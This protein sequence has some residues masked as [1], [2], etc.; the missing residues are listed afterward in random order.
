VS[1]TLVFDG[2]REIW[3][4]WNVQ[5]DLE[6]QGGL[7]GVTM[8]PLAIVF[9]GSG[10]IWNGNRFFFTWAKD[11]WLFLTADTYSQELVDAFSAVVGYRPLCRYRHRCLSDTET[12]AWYV[13][14]EE[15]LKELR[16]EPGVYGLERMDSAQ[17]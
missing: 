4:W 5:L 13:D 11:R 9:G 14:A 1:E 12:V 15:G 10:G 16:A 6:E 8:D 3:P 2:E 7:E 17:S